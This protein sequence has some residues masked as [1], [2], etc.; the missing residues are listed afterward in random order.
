[1]K[2]ALLLKILYT[3][4]KVEADYAPLSLMYEYF[5]KLHQ[6]YVG[7]QIIQAR[8]KS[9]LKFLFNT[10]MG[11]AFILTPKNAAEGFYFDDDKLD[12]I[13]YAKDIAMKINPEAAETIQQEM[14]AFTTKMSTLNAKLPPRS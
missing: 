13:G 12:F 5:G 3:T 2:L 6:H 10:S 9:R 11:F 4:G 7:N 1:M 14:Y 8:V